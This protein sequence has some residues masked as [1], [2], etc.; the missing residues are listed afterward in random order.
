[1]NLIVVSDH[2]MAATGAKR[3]IYLQDYVDSTAC[4]MVGGNA[5]V[6]LWPTGKSAEDL[7]RAL[8]GAHPHLQV[9]AKA[10][11]PE[12]FHY[13]NSPRILPVL[14]LADDGW[15][16]STRSRSDPREVTA[17][18]HG[19]DNALPSMRATFLARGPAFARGLTVPPFE[20]IH[21]YSLICEIL[22][23]RP[24]PN[25]GRLD[26]VRPVLRP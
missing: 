1:V 3:V 12:R 9:Y 2:G 25:D 18:M 15:L 23:L 6:G 19:Y 16:V 20:S 10:D 7:L 14:C 11:I 13:R 5:L 22:G 24:A 21:I 26:T 17:G 4:E 8:K